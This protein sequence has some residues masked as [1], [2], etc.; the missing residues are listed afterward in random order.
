MLPPTLVP[1]PQNI[2]STPYTI[3][4]QLFRFE[5]SVGLISSLLEVDIYFH[6][7]G[8]GPT[9]SRQSNVLNFGLYYA[10]HSSALGQDLLLVIDN[11]MRGPYLRNISSK[12][13]G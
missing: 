7:S 6:P 5:C 11:T 2:L 13:S 10:V 3:V 1:G 9:I 12:V 4:A 8:R